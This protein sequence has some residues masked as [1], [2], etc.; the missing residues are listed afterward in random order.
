M[1]SEKGFYTIGVLGVK[2][3][4]VLSKSPWLAWLEESEER[5]ARLLTERAAVV[6]GVPAGAVCMLPVHQNETVV[7]EWNE[8]AGLKA[9]RGICLQRTAER[10][11]SSQFSGKPL[12]PGA[13]GGVESSP[14]VTRDR[15][16]N[17]SIGGI[18]DKPTKLFLKK[19]PAWNMQMSVVPVGNTLFLALEEGGEQRREKLVTSLSLLV[20][21]FHNGADS[22]P[23]KG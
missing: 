16:W 9:R 14:L 6:V 8:Q 18:S 1:P 13:E 7:W 10:A 2:G 15:Q 11:G 20:V 23:L 19:E 12:E 3:T 22:R 17:I 21:D 4:D 5:E